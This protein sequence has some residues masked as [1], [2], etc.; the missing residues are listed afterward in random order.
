MGGVKVREE[1]FA[2][3]NCEVWDIK[4]YKTTLWMWQG[5]TLKERSKMDDIP[6]G[7]TCL[8]IDREKPIPDEKISLPKAAIVVKG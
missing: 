8:I 4:R 1:S 2:G 6:V 7:R 3:V 5:L